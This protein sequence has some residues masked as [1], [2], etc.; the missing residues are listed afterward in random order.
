MSVTSRNSLVVIALLV[1]SILGTSCSKPMVQGRDREMEP[2]TRTYSAPEEDVFE[3]T[4]QA[5]KD[6]KYKVEYANKYDG[7]L[8]TGWKPT[9]IDSHYVALFGR[10]DYGTTGS[11]YHLAVRMKQ[12]DGKTLVEVQAPVRGI[13]AKMKTSHRVE[14]DLLDEIADNLRP[15]DVN[16]TNIGVVEKR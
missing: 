6:L 14:S 13:V 1:S 10:K 16:I 3:A 5:L 15:A 8:R 9:T 11:Y 4:E 7:V 2:L 12:E